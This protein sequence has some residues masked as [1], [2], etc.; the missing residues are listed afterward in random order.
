MPTTRAKTA[1]ARKMLPSLSHRLAVQQA[2]SER[3]RTTATAE[4]VD[5]EPDTEATGTT[6]AAAKEYLLL[7]CTFAAPD[8]PAQ[9]S[10]AALIDSGATNCYMDTGFA[11]MYDLPLQRLPTPV[12]LYNADGSENS[13]GDI[14]TTC[15]VAMKVHTHIETVTF[16]TTSI[17]YPVVLGYAWLRKHN[18]SINWTTKEIRLD[19]CTGECGRTEATSVV[20]TS[21]PYLGGII[22]HPHAPLTFGGEGPAMEE[23]DEI[24]APSIAETAKRRTS[25]KKE[26]KT[27][28]DEY[29]EQRKRMK[30][31]RAA[32]SRRN[33]SEDF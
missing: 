26:R 23:Q 11:R 10:I 9:V 25:N 27:R 22:A 29:R 13:A 14:L 5:T 33:S 7:E 1:H 30:E 31:S 24:F 32:R 28:G 20:N 8:E 2:L 17:K 6:T 15:T 4:E 19:N 18:P 12:K 21:S 16:Y 3:S